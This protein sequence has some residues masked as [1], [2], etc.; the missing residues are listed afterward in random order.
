MAYTG[1]AGT[2]LMRMLETA[3]ST[4]HTSSQPALPL[5]S[6]IEDR[7]ECRQKRTEAVLKR[8]KTLDEQIV[9]L[10]A[11]NA[12]TGLADGFCWNRWERSY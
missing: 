5:C 1:I 2:V 10:S 6:A 4:A 3:G 9:Q 12:S 11:E 7:L 8:F